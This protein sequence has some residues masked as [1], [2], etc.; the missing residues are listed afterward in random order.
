MNVRLRDDFR[1]CAAPIR[2]TRRSETISGFAPAARRK[3][4]SARRTQMICGVFWR[5]NLL[6]LPVTVIGV[7]SNL[8]VRDGGIRGVVIRLPA[9][10]GR[11]AV[12]GTGC[13]PARRPLTPLSLGSPPS[14]AWRARIPARHSRHDRRGLA[15]E[16]WL[17]RREIKDVFVEATRCR[18]QR[19]QRSSRPR[20]A[21][22]PSFRCADDL[23]FVEAVFE[24]RPTIAQDVE[25]T[26]ERLSISE[27]TQPVRAQTGGS[28]FK[29]PPGKKA[30][31]LID[32]A[33]C[34]GLM[35]G[36]AQVRRCTATS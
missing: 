12:E 5:T 34:R 36:A 1:R 11:F 27:A 22:V 28:T 21:F 32:A 31:E 19:A 25:R 16:R 30:W 13:A 33:G 2:N 35:R 3:F 18:S 14:R 17:L 20:M 10:F 15:H 9:S 23:I 4:C 7:G 26:H 24:G 29:N 6:R 8:L